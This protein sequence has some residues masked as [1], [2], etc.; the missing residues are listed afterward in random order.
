MKLTRILPKFLVKSYQEEDLQQAEIHLQYHKGT[1][2]IF[3]E[4]VAEDRE[5]LKTG[6]KKLEVITEITQSHYVVLVILRI[7]IICI[8]LIYNIKKMRSITI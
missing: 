4:R 6:G 7:I 1:V 5:E 8:V 3:E 2:R